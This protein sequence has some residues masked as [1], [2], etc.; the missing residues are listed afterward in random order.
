MFCQM[1]N[2]ASCLKVLLI[3]QP[4]QIPIWSYLILLF[5]PLGEI[6]QLMYSRWE[7]ELWETFLFCQRNWTIQ[8]IVTQPKGVYKDMWTGIPLIYTAAIVMSTSLHDW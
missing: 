8:D 7:V 2:S 3:W 6:A 5:E 4:C 1:G